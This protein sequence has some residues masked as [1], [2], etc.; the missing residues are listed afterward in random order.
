MNRTA[1][2]LIFALAFFL[3]A[4]IASASYS[5]TDINNYDYVLGQ[6]YVHSMEG[7]EYV[8]EMPI[9]VYKKGTSDLL[10]TEN[11]L[12]IVGNL[13]KVEP[14]FSRVDISSLPAEISSYTYGNPSVDEYTGTGEVTGSYYILTDFGINRKSQS[15]DEF[16]S[17]LKGELQKEVEGSSAKIEYIDK[18]VNGH[19]V[20]GVLE[21]V[22]DSNW[23][24][25][26]INTD[27]HRSNRF[28]YYV[29]R[30]DFYPEGS[31]FAYFKIDGS[32]SL[33]HTLGR[34]LSSYPYPSESQINS[35]IS[36][37]DR[38][39]ASA[40]TFLDSVIDDAANAKAKLIVGNYDEVF[41]GYGA[42][43]FSI[44]TLAGG[45]GDTD[46]GIPLVIVMGILATGAA[47]A[48]ASAAAGEGVIESGRT[49]TY[50]M[51]IRKDFGDYIKCGADPETLYA[52]IIETTAEGNEIER[53]DLSSSITMSSGGGLVVGDQA[54]SGGYMAA[55]ISATEGE[56]AEEGVVRVSYTGKGGSFTNN[57][58]FRIIG[59]P[60]IEFPE[61][62][63]A[64]DM[65]LN[66]FYGDGLTYD[67]E[68]ELVNFLEPPKEIT[69]S[70]SDEAPVSCSVGKA[71][72]AA[73]GDNRYIV[74][75]V[76]N[77]PL[78]EKDAQVMSFP[79]WVKATTSEDKIVEDSFVLYLYPEGLSVT[80]V[81]YDKEG[82]AQFAAYDDTNTEEDDVMETDF[83]VNLAVRVTENG[84][85]VVKLVEGIDYAPEF[86]GLKGTDQKTGVLTSKFRY[87]IEKRPD[88][89]NKAYKFMPSQQVGEPDNDPYYLTL[90]I[91]CEYSNETYELDLPVRLIGDKLG[92]RSDRER[93]LELLKRRVQKFGM[94]P[95]VARFL[96]ENAGSLSAAQIR[97][98]SKKIVYD[99]IVYYTQESADF[100][101]TAD[102][103][104]EWINYLTVVKWF[105]DQ[106]FSYLA[107]I[108]FG[109]AAEAILTPAKEL[110]VE[111]VGELS[112]DLFM[113]YPVDWNEIKS[114]QHISE[115]IENYVKSCFEDIGKVSPKK[116]A[117]V[118][119][120]LCM[121]NLIRHYTFDLD[122]NGKR[123]WYNA[124][125]S[126]FSDI[127][128]EFF[129]NK[130][131]S[132]LKGKLDDPN[133]GISKLLKSSTVR[134]LEE[135]MPEGRLS[136]PGVNSLTDDATMGTA[137]KKYVEEA[138]GLGASYVTQT[139][140]KIAA[141]GVFVK[142]NIGESDADRGVDWYIVVDPIKA[143]DKVFEYIFTSLYESF[144][145]PTAEP[146]PASDPRDPFYM[147]PSNNQKIG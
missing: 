94:S 7:D 33:T 76:N 99:S 13:G 85:E 15:L 121:F 42:G 143:A 12:L 113:G 144:P 46:Y 50:R 26:G 118:I 108:Y 146:G 114:G 100:M 44:N 128:L 28:V 54:L 4:G 117:S 131:G 75:V 11:S 66:V 71:D 91:S 77:S 93:E 102:S 1:K 31:G 141:E 137:L 105:G 84:K 64:L 96:R 58:R 147:N 65:R 61:Q 120:G 57:I 20:V 126:A 72:K 122:E 48:G 19:R 14:E 63:D 39:L 87:E 34:K 80:G 139:A 81:V 25:G 142:V 59:K 119:A 9:D 98:I 21:V 55:L 22:D 79:I 32:F 82:H 124:F 5:L 24:A 43:A 136:V 37:M 110:S 129:K 127:S 112:S 138:F 89:T 45:P 17:Y 41:G 134:M 88:N 10:A 47:L 86:G 56:T 70:K 133:S 51:R 104:N 92:V 69:V 67:V 35:A 106:A 36:E 8:V 74:K 29:I 116:L 101:Q 23:K 115:M 97:L 125:I 145:F 95:E 30:E 27:N 16:A 18:T 135:M 68:V 109:P 132:F 60:R 123:S 103:M 140:G 107:T 111:I 49:S 73:A 40:M 62:G 130:F 3:L 38:A 52:A 6:K 83:F 53:E 78:P 2:V 90:P